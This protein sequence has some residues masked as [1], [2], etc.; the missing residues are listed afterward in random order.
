MKKTIKAQILDTVAKNQTEIVEF[1]KELVAIATENPPGAFYKPCV[2]AIKNKLSE[3]GLDHEIIEVPNQALKRES[4]RFPR[5]CILS[6]YGAGEKTLYLHGHYDVVPASSKDQ[7]QSYLK[8]GKLFGRGASDMKSGLAAMIYA[9]KAIKDSNVELNGKIGLTVVPDE[10]TGGLLGSKYLADIEVLGKNGIGMLLPEPTSG[11]VWNANRGAISLRV[12]VK[13]K[14]A[15]VGLQYRGNN[16]FENMLT[17]ANALLE[18]KK[19]VESRT[20]GY[21]IQPDPA[22]HSILMMGGRS[23][24]GNNFNLVPGEFSF[25]V[26]RRINPEE[27]FEV[28]KQRLLTLFEAVKKDGIDLE[29]ET[30]QEGESSGVSRNHPIAQVL[31]RNIEAITG[32]RP[33]FE[34]CPGLLE[35][36]FYA[37]KGI[38]AFAYG[39]GLLSVSHGPD[40]F[41]KVENIYECAVIYALTAVE[42]LSD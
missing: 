18:L 10:E 20:T 13:G 24:G 17:V 11:V 16:A 6:S 9:V 1:T 31:T 28:E 14:P 29:I 25:T 22:R 30:L 5:Y 35:I 21:N 27:D 8:D 36:R 37:K 42:T 41:V 34:M 7:F 2:K 26:D 15:H 40:E 23:E 3:I 33:R 12:N 38:P 4:Q 32:K 39:P 19:A